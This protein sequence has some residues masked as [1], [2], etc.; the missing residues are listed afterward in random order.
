MGADGKD[1]GPD[2][3]LINKKYDKSSLLN[4][5][6]NPNASIVFGYEP[7]L[8]ETK[9]G[10]T[11]YGFILADDKTVVIKDISGIKHSIRKED[12]TKRNKQSKTVMPSAA[13][14]G[15]SNIDLANLVGYLNA[16]K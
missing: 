15:L 12:I 14:M 11:F 7:W 3:T 10:D 1:I 8:I 4:A 16:L 9:E 6:I 13:S 5:I 2:L